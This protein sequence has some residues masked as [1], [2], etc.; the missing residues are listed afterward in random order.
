MFVFGFELGALEKASIDE[1]D[2]LKVIFLK[3]ETI[4]VC[5]PKKKIG[6]LILNFFNRANAL[7]FA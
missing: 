3:F 6:N 5:K 4:S 2:S 7:F 1:S